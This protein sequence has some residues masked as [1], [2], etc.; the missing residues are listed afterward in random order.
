[1]D[2]R[3]K[4]PKWIQVYNVLFGGLQKFNSLIILCT[5]IFNMSSGV[6]SDTQTRTL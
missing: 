2:K 4:L 6:V 3:G 5:N 1:M